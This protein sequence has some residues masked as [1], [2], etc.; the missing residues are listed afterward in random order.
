ME[1]LQ[2]APQSSAF[3]SLAEHQSRTP[4][5]FY[6]GP[7]VL[8]YHSANCKI[9]VHSHDLR[10]SSPLSSLALKDVPNTNGHSANGDGADGADDNDREVSIRGVD[11][12]VTSLLVVSPFVMLKK[13]L[14]L[15]FRKFLLWST[16][17]SSG[18]SIPYPSISLHAIQRLPLPDAESAH[19]GLYMQLITSAEV[20]DE[21]EDLDT[22]S[23]TLIPT[24][25]AAAASTAPS[26]IPPEQ[27][28]TQALFDALSAC[29]NLHP[30]PAPD[31]DGQMEGSSLFAAGLIQPGG[32]D[33]DLPPP[34]PG[35]GGW[36]T[37]ENMGEY[38]DEEGNWIGGGEDEGA[39]V[40]EGDENGLGPGAGTV[41]ARD[42][43]GRDG[44]DGAGAEDTK[45][46]RTS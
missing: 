27:S 4:A 23:L 7:A 41:R 1:V 46:Q 45:W 21:D 9:L 17:S 11:I 42:E 18:V 28:P 26:D 5:S 39:E 14:L 10:G 32:T 37:A 15:A 13:C 20:S 40:E 3:T 38:F 29:S 35:S 34:M 33:G 30:D 36:I 19:S 6:S 12:W 31:T 8:H 22:I 2:E 44:A 16:Q 24:A 43:E 25:L